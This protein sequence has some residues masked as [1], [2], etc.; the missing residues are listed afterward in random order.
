MSTNK[1]YI[2]NF[3]KQLISKEYK[4]QQSTEISK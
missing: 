3:Q 2:N 1:S 4:N